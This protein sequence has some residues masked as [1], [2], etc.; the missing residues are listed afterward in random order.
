[1]ATDP[2]SPDDRPADPDEPTGNA[3]PEPFSF[4]T[5]DDVADNPPPA[6][7]PAPIEVEAS[8]VWD[9]PAAPEPADL[10]PVGD[11]LDAVDLTD[12]VPGGPSDSGALWYHEQAEP[13]S[14][15]H[16]EPQSSVMSQPP[17][18][19][20]SQPPSSILGQPP[21]GVM[22]GPGSDVIRGLFPGAGPGSHLFNPGTPS[23]QSAASASD[24]GGRT[25]SIPQSE[26][27]K[28]QDGS[29]AALHGLP[30]T[31]RLG[32]EGEKTPPPVGRDS[33]TVAIDDPGPGGS[34][35]QRKAVAA[36]FAELE[37]IPNPP[38]HHTARGRPTSGGEVD[39]AGPDFNETDPS[40]SGSNLF[41]DPSAPDLAL[42]GASEVVGTAANLDLMNPY[43]GPPSGLLVGPASSI[44]TRDDPD[45]PTS[46]RV[47]LESSPG[48]DDDADATEAFPMPSS[49]ASSLVT[50]DD[51]PKSPLHDMLAS[52]IIRRSDIGSTADALGAVSFDS[53]GG[54]LSAIVR[55]EASGMIDWTA[56]PEIEDDQPTPNLTGDR[57]ISLD[58][59]ALPSEDI[60]LPEPTG[61]I[62]RISDITPVE[63][64]REPEPVEVGGHGRAGDRV[65]GALVGL[66]AGVAA[67]VAAYFGGLVPPPDGPA[68]PVVSAVTST[69][70]APAATPTDGKALLAAGD[71]TAA[72][73]AFADAPADAPADI[74]AARGQARVLARL[75]EL[76]S[77]DG[78]VPADDAALKKAEA[79]LS[80][81]VTGTDSKAAVAAA[82]HLGL[83]KEVTG[84]AAGAAKVYADAAQKFPGA[85]PVFE[86]ALNRLKAMSEKPLAGARLAPVKAD[87]LARAALFA[88]ILLQPPAAAE[89]PAVADE[90]G[91]L[92]WQAVNDAAA[93][94]YAAAIAGVAQARKLHDKKR[95]AV[96]GRGGVNPTSD[97]LDQIF[98]KSCDE[99][100]AY[101]TLKRDLYA[102]PK[103]GD[104]V[105]ANGVT[106]ALDQFA[107]ADA[108][109]KKALDDAKI[110]KADYELLLKDFREKFTQMMVERIKATDDLTAATRRAA[111]AET[112]SKAADAALA[113]VTAELKA[114]GLLT[115]PTDLSKVPAAIKAAVSSA[116]AKKA[117]ELLAA[118]K[119]DADDAR[120]AAKAAADA[121]AKAE[122]ANKTAMAK[123]TADA[124]KAKA[125]ADA[126]MKKAADDLAA[127][128]KKADD[129]LAVAK[130]ALAD[131]EATA[132]QAAM[133]EAAERERGLKER[134]AAA[135]AAREQ[136]LAA[137]A[138]KHDEA[139]KTLRAG[140]RVLASAS[141]QAARDRA[142]KAFADGVLLYQG[143]RLVE[144]EAMLMAA[145]MN[146]PNDARYWYFLGLT[147]WARGSP[148]ADAAFRHGAE[149]EARGLPPAG[150]VG[151]MLERVQGPARQALAAYRP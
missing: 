44:F 66:V 105:K 13:P 94:N 106:K 28:H 7:D 145:T 141:E 31:D 40:A 24:L 73:K 63:V 10:P 49:A 60:I 55:A 150:R 148:A 48:H 11:D 103:V 51:L 22:A 27:F 127:A 89:P 91:F 88:V 74:R 112:K 111:E 39:P 98:L 34:S 97:P 3:M 15:I 54:P 45:G 139:V 41:A 68:K 78:P 80:S 64:H 23:A 16:G 95:L 9:L 86:A 135:I 71:P 126:A 143:G 104:V 144:A 47:D 109:A 46:G 147:R 20:L 1:M 26:L 61:Q 79:D 6:F 83:L 99:L 123:L 35:A 14:S 146:D 4:L 32:G 137:Q 57:P 142:G 37:A 72:M 17:S 33:A 84:D 130:K 19:I 82:L 125:D 119:K 107:A 108:A 132:K 50:A 92:F 70:V 5:D 38:A 76:A 134:L 124:E 43:A 140:G 117:T 18:S 116:D 133:A 12:P 121:A 8:D 100:T 75:R 149:L 53:P 122:E 110:E 58:D 30:T 21:S 29:G 2:A 96:L 151:P 69:V 25:D 120:A 85:K 102:H 56:P 138:A 67:S 36:L 65:G 87:E 131:A 115:D 77:A 90:P 129:E 93:G 128:R 113:A 114:N 118:A 101:W 81:A 59:L 136:D 42:P 62:G 52:G